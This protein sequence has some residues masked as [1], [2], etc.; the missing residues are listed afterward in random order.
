[1]TDRYGSDVLA[2]RKLAGEKPPVPSVPADL[3]LVVEDAETGW[4]GAVVAVEKAGGMHVVH[5][6]GR[7][8]RRRGFPLGP[9]FL[10]D[11]KPVSLTAPVSAG[12]TRSTRTASGSTAVQHARARVARAGRIWVEGQHDAEL[13]EKIWGAD[14][15]IEG[16]VVEPLHGIDDLAE[17]VREHG[18]G[19][20]RRLGILVDHLIPRSKE[21][22]LVEATRR[23][24]G[25]PHLLIVG[26]P[27]VDVWQ[28]VRPA[29]LGLTNWPVIPRGL[30]WKNGVLAHLERP[31]RTQEDIAVGWQWILSTVSTYSDLEPALLGKVEELIDFVTEDS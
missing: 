28:G 12:P 9:G 22:R 31:H 21:S 11:G 14:L 4:C 19:P 5:L 3:N 13:I 7:H 2:A 26:H 15:R 8:G 16:V 10:I 1:M 25:S 30:L 24:I 23:T 6:E 18:P 29:Q 27:F 20:G 17:A